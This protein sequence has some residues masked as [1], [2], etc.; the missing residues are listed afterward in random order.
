MNEEKYFKNI[1]LISL[2][3]ITLN[4]GFEDY[5]TLILWGI[6]G[7]FWLRSELFQNPFLYL[8]FA[9]YQW[10]FLATRWYAVDNH[11]FLFAWWLL[12]LFFALFKNENPKEHLSFNA[13]L[14][15]GIV[16][17]VAATRKAIEPSFLDGS[18]FEFTLLTDPRFEEIPLFL[19]DWNYGDL[20]SFRNQAVQSVTGFLGGQIQRKGLV[21]P[22]NL[23]MIAI[24]LTYWTIVIEA[25]IAIA[26]LLP[27]RVYIAYTRTAFLGLFCITSYIIVPVTSFGIIMFVF[28]LAAK[29]VEVESEM[30]FDLINWVF[31]GLIAASSLLA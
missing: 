30:R 31:I 4:S 28:N 19:T 18:F 12:A 20:K 10:A 3:L 21:I 22:E 6:L 14:I 7:T 11:Q 16:M 29:P 2:I 17:G 8:G 13:R 23:P 1:G 5:R 27:N 9:V 26:F 25:I 15:L 24:V